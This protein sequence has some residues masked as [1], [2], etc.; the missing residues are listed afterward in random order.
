MLGN[1]K[2]RKSVY[3]TY[4]FSATRDKYYIVCGAKKSKG[5]YENNLLKT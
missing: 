4:A 5:K 2:M 3:W 1:K